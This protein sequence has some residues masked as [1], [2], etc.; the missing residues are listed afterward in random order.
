MI[1]RHSKFWL[2]T[3]W[4]HGPRG[5]IPWDRKFGSEKGLPPI[6]KK[7]AHCPLVTSA[8]GGFTP[9]ERKFG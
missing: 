8:P 1:C 4:S 5:F 7:K 2:V 9:P 6:T 3:P